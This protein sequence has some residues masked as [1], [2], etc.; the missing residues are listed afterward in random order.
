MILAKGGRDSIWNTWKYIKDKRNRHKTWMIVCCILLLFALAG[1]VI[2]GF[3]AN[4][5]M[6]AGGV[7]LWHSDLCGIWEFPS[8]STSDEAATRS[9]VVLRLKEARAGEYAK[10]CY[11]PLSSNQPLPVY[12][13]FFAQKNISFEESHPW[14]CPFPNKTA[15][16]GSQAVTF[17]TGKLD[18][19]YLGINME[20]PYQFRRNATCVPLNVN[21]PYVQSEDHNGTQVF[22]YYYG[23]WNDADDDTEPLFDT[24]GDPF[25][26]NV[27]TYD[28]R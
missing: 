12:C 16:I 25:G 9:D 10:Y 28:V 21:E 5:L 7:A 13:N 24:T 19:S 23:K 15:C 17:D 18:A 2:L 14:E 8:D 4:P 20:N 27:P 6:N 22:K 3:A 26:W 11:E 1:I